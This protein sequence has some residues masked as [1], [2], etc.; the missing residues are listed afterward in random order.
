MHTISARNVNDA[1]AQGL[2]YLREFGV[3]EDSRAGPVLVAPTPVTTVYTQ[4]RERVLLDPNRDANPFL[5]LFEALHMLAGRNDARWLDRFVRDFSSRFAEDDGHQHGAYGHRWR[6]HFDMEGGG[7]PGLPDQIETVVRLLRVNPD[8]RRV[9]LTMWDPV[10][11][12]GADMRDIPCNT[13]IYPRVRSLSREEETGMVLDIPE[14]YHGIPQRVLDITVCCR[15]NDA[16]WGCYGANSVHFSVLQ[17]YLAGRIGVGVG[18]YYQVSNNFHAYVDVLKKVG[19]PFGHQP[20]EETADGTED[21]DIVVPFPIGA[22]W[23][24][25]DEDLARFMA[26]TERAGCWEYPQAYPHNPWFEHT[27]QPLFAAHYMW[28]DEANLWGWRAGA[29]SAFTLLAETG[30]EEYDGVSDW[31][32]AAEEWL[33]RRVERREAKEGRLE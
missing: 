17:E 23:S 30:A 18:R 2:A 12:L 24:C 4:S 3:R 29:H 27:A 15:S 32:R 14:K 5:H 10:A 21:G 16:I 26:W 7:H 1:Y 22:D 20:Y 8:D 11:D 28:R 33:R 9:V 25:W 6:R 13:H 31:H 19:E